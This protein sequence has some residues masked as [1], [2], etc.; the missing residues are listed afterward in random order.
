MQYGLWNLVEQSL[1]CVSAPIQSLFLNHSVMEAISH[2]CIFKSA[3]GLWGMGSFG[4]LKFCSFNTRDHCSFKDLINMFV[5]RVIKQMS[6]SVT[7]FFKS[8]HIIYFNHILFLRPTPLRYQPPYPPYVMFFLYE[9]QNKRIKT[10][11][12]KKQNKHKNRESIL[13]WSTPE[14]ESCPGST[15]YNCCHFVGENWFSLS[16]LVSFT[17]SFLVWGF[18]AYCPFSVLGFWLIL[19][20]TIY[21]LSFFYF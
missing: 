2:V 10:A 4:E 15:W 18:C 19:T 21:D 7:F 16:Q 8:F 12:N 11:W 17:I 14:N 6:Y 20:V 9:K 13:C 1:S 3:F 5:N